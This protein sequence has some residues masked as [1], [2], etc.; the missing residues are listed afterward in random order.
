MIWDMEFQG[1]PEGPFENF[2]FLVDVLWGYLEAKGIPI[3]YIRMIKDMYD[4][5]KTR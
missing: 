5:A 3:V 1:N 2:L 4:G